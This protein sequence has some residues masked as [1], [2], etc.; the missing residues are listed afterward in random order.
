VLSGFFSS[1]TL[2]IL[3]GKHLLAWLTHIQ[4][5]DILHFSLFL[6]GVLWVLSSVIIGHFLPI[7]WLCLSAFHLFGLM[8]NLKDDIIALP[9]HE[10]VYLVYRLAYHEGKV[11]LEC[12]AILLV[13]AAVFSCLQ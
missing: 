3:I 11:G 12:V 9:V 2:H 1:F 7:K 6:K 13:L 10:N 5:S 8:A 4:L